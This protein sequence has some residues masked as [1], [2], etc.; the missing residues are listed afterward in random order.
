[1]VILL[2]TFSTIAAHANLFENKSNVDTIVQDNNG[3]IW[4][5]G[6]NG[7]TR[8]DGQMAMNFS[9]NNEKW[10]LPF[11]WIN[12]TTK[13]AN[14]LLLATEKKGIWQFNPNTGM[15]TPIPLNADN[16][17]VYMALHF[18]DSYFAIGVTPNDLYYLND[19]TAQTQR[20]ATDISSHTLLATKQQV[21][22]VKNNTLHKVFSYPSQTINIQAEP[23]ISGLIM[24]ST[25]VNS[26]AV[27]ATQKHLYLLN[28]DKQLKQIK[29]IDRVTAI[30]ISDDKKSFFT[31]NNKGE[32]SKYRL[33][34]LSKI[35]HNFPTSS[36]DYYQAIFQDNSQVIWLASNHGVITLSENIL[37][38]YNI[39][40]KTQI[41][42][43]ET[44]II[45]E[46]IIIGNYGM[47]L[48]V[49][50]DE[51]IKYQQEVT[52]LN[53][54]FSKF[55]K[56]IT[57]LLPVGDQLF[58]ATFDGLWQLDTVNHHLKFIDFQHAEN[59]SHRVFLKLRAIGEL[60]YIATDAVG[61]IVYDMKKKV[62]VDH[63]N[64]IELSSKE[65]TDILILNNNNVWLTT[66]GGL[67]VYN[68]THH[69]IR[70]IN[71]NITSKYISLLEVKGKIFV[72]TKGDGIFV[73]NHQGDLLYHFAQ[74]I[75]FSYMSLINGKILASASP[76]IYQIAPEN[77]QITMLPNTD[78][79]SFTDAPIL[80][81]N[82]IYIGHFNGVLSLPQNNQ[83]IY[84]P[85]V[86]ISKTTVS[87][88]SYLLN[89]MMKISTSNDVISLDLAS[90]D[91]R[92]GKEK[93]YRYRINNNA[94][95]MINGS[96]LT[97]TGLSPGDYSIEIMA[98]NSL[99]QW[100]KNKAYTD[101]S[102]AYPW[103]WTPILR[104][105]YSLMLLII[106]L[107]SCWLL[108]LRTKSISHIH[109]ILQSEI[110][111]NSKILLTIRRHLQ[112]TK[113][114]LQE[115]KIDQADLLIQQSIDELDN[116]NKDQV[117][118][119][120]YGK[121]LSIALPFFSEYVLNKYQIHVATRL[122]F[123]DE[124][125]S[126]ELQT[127][128]YKIIYEAITSA[129]LN[130]EGRNFNILLQEFKGKLWLTISDNTNSFTQ[131][132][133]KINFDMSMYYIRQIATKYK[134]SVN[135]F[136]DA[137]QGSQLVISVPLMDLL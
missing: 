116:Q 89:K 66:A 13:D 137:Q 10:S 15:T 93:I 43:F 99:G 120:L 57:D 78:N 5:S 12:Q 64:N 109:E 28:D 34:D 69:T 135:T 111:S 127:D 23:R 110:N 97:L 124:Q 24:A 94:W 103:Y 61:V 3:L 80:F 20:I 98:T 11:T 74:G 32:L 95:N 122:E 56:K 21:Y 67:D 46:K 125:L 123:D 77:Y 40:F 133:S 25:S 9:H 72:A 119:N 55:G 37:H 45:N 86:L 18:Y 85:K 38:N 63:I 1:M 29:L 114:F 44:A 106:I 130:G 65:I 19:L 14:Q 6:Q 132:N 112:L 2:L 62:I 79:Y 84:H 54:H 35:P 129:V 36:P 90:V 17:T 121:N 26:T 16:N 102:V 53:Q 88:S 96:Q 42:A 73:Y 22:F 113:T 105:I 60:L 7:L 33:S 71:S 100:S 41:N 59:I 83:P 4:L 39:P 49:L 70:N 107:L 58:I 75:D 30:T 76:G 87:G 126:Y 47:G 117:P 50:P 91:Y 104:I 27:I 82:T 81:K 131:F 31:I 108:F 101:I 92:H 136:N 118:D 115:Q 52:H 51:E 68:R 134:A 128:I 48:H 8:F